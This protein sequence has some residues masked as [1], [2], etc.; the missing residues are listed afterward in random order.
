MSE[1]EPHTEMLNCVAC[2]VPNEASMMNADFLCPICA[3]LES[4]RVTMEKS[5]SRRRELWDRRQSQ[6]NS[7][8]PPSDR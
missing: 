1:A 4:L 3:A 7:S 6:A 2:Q 8:L 5:G